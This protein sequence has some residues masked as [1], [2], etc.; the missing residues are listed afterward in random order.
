M[1]EASK[2]RITRLRAEIAFLRDDERGG[3]DQTD[4]RRKLVAR[5]ARIEKQARRRERK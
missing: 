1:D 5:I 3:V 4:E 2:V